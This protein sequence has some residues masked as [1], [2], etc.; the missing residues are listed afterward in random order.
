MVFSEGLVVGGGLIG[1][2]GSDDSQSQMSIYLTKF[3]V[4]SVVDGEK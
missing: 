1:L 3:W 2:K 4:Y